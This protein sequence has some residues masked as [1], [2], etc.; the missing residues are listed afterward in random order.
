MLW[1]KV[2]LDG[3]PSSEDDRPFVVF[4]RGLHEDI[5]KCIAMGTFTTHNRGIGIRPAGE[6][7]YHLANH[8]THW[9]YIDGPWEDV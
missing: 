2:T 8:V 3:I 4:Y 5:N 1:R 7:N 9:A 6:R